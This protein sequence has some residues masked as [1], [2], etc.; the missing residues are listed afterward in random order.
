MVNTESCY[1][2]EVLTWRDCKAVIDKFLVTENY[3]NFV[4]IHPDPEGIF[5]KLKTKYKVIQAAGGLIMNEENKLLMIFRRG[6]W[7]LPKGKLDDGETIEEAAVR[8]VKEETGLSD[9]VLQKPLGVSYHFFSEYKKNILKETFWF[10][11]R[12][13]SADAVVPQ[14]EEEI[15]KVEWCDTQQV[16]EYLQNS[17]RN[18]AELI[19]RYSPIL[20]EAP[21][22]K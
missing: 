9:I 17:Y 5:L 18:I 13:S 3:K 20:T 21:D 16:K 12:G 8:E 22:V 14:A 2:A 7:D 1:F 19:D 6:K 11:M 15:E 4:L 10:E